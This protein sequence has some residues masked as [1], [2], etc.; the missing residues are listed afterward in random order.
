MRSAGSI[1]L[2]VLATCISLSAQN[3]VP[4]INNPLVP[5]SAAP[6]AAGFQL[7]VNGVGFV[8]GSVV[9]WN[10]SPR[11]TSFVSSSQLKASIL[12]SD[13]AALGT[14]FVTVSSPTPGGGVSN[15]ATFEVTL[16]APSEGFT[17][18]ST[19]E[20]N[21]CT[22]SVLFPQIVAD[23]NG[24]GK[25]DVAGTV[26]KGGFLYISLGNGDGTFQAPI[27]TALLPSPG[28]MV[29]GDFN[30]DG[31][32]D[33]AVINDTNNVALLLGNGDGTFQAAKNF[34]TGLGADTLAVGDFNGD[35]KLDLIL[36]ANTA[37]D[38]DTLLGNGDGTFKPYI[39][40]STGGAFPFGLAIGDFNGDGKLDLVTSESGSSEVTVMFGN[41]DGTFT[42]NT[43]YFANLSFI[44]AVDM[45]GDGILDLVG[46]GSPLSGGTTGIA[47]MYGNPG[48]TF[49]NPVQV[50]TP[51]VPFQ[52][53]N[54]FGIAD[55]NGDG[56]L[57]FWAIGSAGDNLGTSR[58][59]Q[60]Y[61]PNAGSLQRGASGIQCRPHGGGRF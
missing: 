58:E 8:S 27:Y 61:V 37:N 24:D 47:I 2:G 34:L 11:S 26:C 49:Q 20:T 21:S 1:L 32:L 3:P 14:V 22:K 52:S 48:G 45:N 38:I 44:I 23:F 18:T 16:P 31:K 46:L 42:F 50:S 35:G 28:T 57:D 19:N 51:T 40:S 4:L 13:L 54:A 56:K 15:T 53:Y 5:E 9:N 59:W 43:N 55:L 41:G 17:S 12:A 10:G 7:T 36:T 25:Q 33:L 60:W 29:A 6:G 39:A 30:G